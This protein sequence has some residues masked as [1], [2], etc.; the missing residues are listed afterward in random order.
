M[1][2]FK[3]FR[4]PVA[5]PEMSTRKIYYNYVL[6]Y[7]MAMRTLE[8]VQHFFPYWNFEIF[9]PDTSVLVSIVYVDCKVLF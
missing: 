5:R 8:G 2:D 9:S 4:T 6:M 1:A 3:T 7:F